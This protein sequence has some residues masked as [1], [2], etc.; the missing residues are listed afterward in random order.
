MTSVLR[1]CHLLPVKQRV[2]YKLCTI[3]N[4]HLYDDAP[5]YLDLITP[6]AGASARAGLRSAESM[7]IA[8][9]ARCHH[10]E[11]AICGGRPACVEQA[12]VTPPS[13]AVR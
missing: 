1:D 11:T 12:T 8:C 2:E 3:V 4:R 7:N 13:D 6:S 5:P 9:H 10:L